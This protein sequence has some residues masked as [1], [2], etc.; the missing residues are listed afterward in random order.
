M[1]FSVNPCTG[2]LE[3]RGGS[4][5]GT[6]TL[7]PNDGDSLTGNNFNVYGAYSNTVKSMETYTQGGDF[8]IANQTFQTQYVV[9]ASTTVGLKGTFTTIQSAINQAVADGAIGSSPRKIF[10]RPGTYTENLLIPAGIILEG[11]TPAKN[12]YLG[13]STTQLVSTI[14]GTHNCSSTSSLVEF[15]N[16]G[17]INNGDTEIF[18]LTNPDASIL[19]D[20]CSLL[21]SSTTASVFSTSGVG[22]KYVF[23]NCTVCGSTSTA[24]YEIVIGSNAIAQFQ[25][26]DFGSIPPLGVGYSTLA[27]NVTSTGSLYI[28][29]CYGIASIN[30][31]STAVLECYD[32]TFVSGTSNTYA[33]YISGTGS[34][35]YLSNCDFGSADAQSTP[36]TSGYAIQ[37]TT[38]TWLM[39]SNM[40]YGC[41]LFETGTVINAGQCNQGDVIQTKSTAISYVANVNDYYIGITDTSSARTITLPNPSLITEGKTFYVKDESGGA[42]TNS[43]TIQASGGAT[44]DGD[45]NTVINSNYG[46]ANIIKRGSVYYVI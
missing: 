18:T 37:S 38:G 39:N 17:F 19:F 30:L 41:A 15:K 4:T 25:N 43:I 36:P 40:A 28:D 7:V 35:G 12:S 29:N 27:F 14:V 11:D 31:A 1:P 24:G 10:I 8:V 45:P 32:S 16:I 2:E 13:I 23:S 21:S 3:F 33:Y 9:D 46:S 6:I 5:G 34:G 44:I 42:G 22:S 26:C 20:S